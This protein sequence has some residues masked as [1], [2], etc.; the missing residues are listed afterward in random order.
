M[1]LLL[2]AEVQAAVYAGYR[3]I[4]IRRCS[5]L[6]ASLGRSYFSH[7]KCELPWALEVLFDCA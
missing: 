4:S 6:S 2:S 3:I 7:L 5:N 1:K